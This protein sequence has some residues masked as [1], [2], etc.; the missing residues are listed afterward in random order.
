MCTFQEGRSK[1][2][3]S[4]ICYYA[5]G[6]LIYLPIKKHNFFILNNVDASFMNQVCGNIFYEL[7]MWKHH[8]CNEFVE[9]S[10]MNQVYENIFFLEIHL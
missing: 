4:N 8:L 10:Y 7:N 5:V 6:L 2:K 9:T 1:N 3:K